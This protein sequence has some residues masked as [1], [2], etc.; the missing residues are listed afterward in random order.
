MV[1]VNPWLEFVL[2]HREVSGFS[3]LLGERLWSRSLWYILGLFRVCSGSFAFDASVMS[4]WRTFWESVAKS[5]V[6]ALL[7]CLGGIKVPGLG[8][9]GRF[10]L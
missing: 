10:L 6:E 1:V 3:R 9:L 4:V 7:L 2:R 8:G 5:W